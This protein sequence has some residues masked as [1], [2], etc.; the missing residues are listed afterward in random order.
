MPG[1]V[2]AEGHGCGKAGRIFSNIIFATSKPDFID[3]TKGLAR[4]RVPYGIN[5]NAIS[6][7]SINTAMIAGFTG[8]KSESFLEI[9][10]LRKFG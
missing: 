1:D 2:A 5:V 8:Q 3:L 6:P 9:I 7:S 4:E 10:S